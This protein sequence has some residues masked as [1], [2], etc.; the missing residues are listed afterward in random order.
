MAG[1][2]VTPETQ[3]D[4]LR[5]M[6]VALLAFSGLCGVGILFSLGRLRQTAG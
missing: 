3:P 6:H 2:A 5:S 4:F 1:H